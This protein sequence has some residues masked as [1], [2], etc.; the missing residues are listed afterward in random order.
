MIQ[1]RLAG[2]RARHT[3][4][5]AVLHAELYEDVATRS[6]ADS[7]PWRP[8]PAAGG[9]S[10]YEPGAPADDSAV[11]SV[12]ERASG[13]LAGEALLWGIDTHNRCAHVG[14]SLRPGSRGRGIGAEAVQLLCRYGFTVRGLHR[15][16]VDTLADNTAM[17]SAARRAGFTLEGTLRRS[18]WVSG[19]FVDE[20]VLGLPVD[21][22]KQP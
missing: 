21:E 11:F 2:L 3:E 12:V 10:P 15:L 13:A 18:A 16:Q 14:V 9:H 8:L 1:G 19:E 4:D 7:R 5:V 20:V 17:I 22:W 6:R